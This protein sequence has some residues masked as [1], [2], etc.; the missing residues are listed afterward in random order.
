MSA[1]RYDE[2]GETLLEL[3]LALIVIALVVG[4]FFA[5]YATQSSGSTAHRTLVTA[6]GV[7]RSYAE[8]TKLAAREQCGSGATHFSVAYTPPSGYEVNSLGNQPCPLP[9]TTTPWAPI[10]LRVKKLPDS[11]PRSL[12]LV[13]RTP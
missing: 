7:L 1:R 13:V 4:S 2:S 11:M 10:E 5:T 12:T 8:A 6:D 9:A 3:V